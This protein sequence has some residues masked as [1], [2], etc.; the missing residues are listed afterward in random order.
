MITLIE[1]CSLLEEFLILH[2]LQQINSITNNYGR[3]LDLILCSNNI[4]HFVT[5]H[6]QAALVKE[7][8][9]HPALE[10]TICSKK[11]KSF[12]KF[13]KNT[14]TSFYNFKK[15]NF[16]MLYESI[17]NIDWSFLTGITDVNL[18]CIAFYNKIYNVCDQYVPIGR[19]GKNTFPN[20]YSAELKNNLILKQKF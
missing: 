3:M 14:N 2:N 18:A 15:A 9:Y 20:W 17:S 13:K 12:V 11:E 8:L 16:P 1:F 5:S 7:D 6:C 10:V 4:E 19:Y